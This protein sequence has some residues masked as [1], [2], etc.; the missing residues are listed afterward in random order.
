LEIS[1]SL[2]KKQVEESIEKPKVVEGPEE[3]KKVIKEPIAKLS[4]EMYERK[5]KFSYFCKNCGIQ[6]FDSIDI[7]FPKSL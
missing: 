6:L 1:K 2:L 4:K 3:E 5:T 7:I